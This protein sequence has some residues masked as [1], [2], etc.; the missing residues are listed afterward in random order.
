MATLRGFTQDEMF[1]ARQ[2]LESS[3]AE[4][5]AQNASPEQLTLLAEEIAAIFASID[6]PDTFLVHDAKFHS[7]VAAASNNPIIAALTGMV[8]DAM[9]KVRRTTVR[10]ASDLKESAEMHHKVYRAIRK[11]N[12]KEAREA[13][14]EHLERARRAQRA[15][16]EVPAGAE[17]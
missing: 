6:D 8:V 13:M 12:P 16:A 5:A 3:A 2:A 14:Q 9:Y 4:L 15:E 11:K 7:L 10:R 1:A 17:H